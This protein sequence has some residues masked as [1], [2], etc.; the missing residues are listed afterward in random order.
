MIPERGDKQR[1]L[2]TF[3]YQCQKLYNAK[4]SSVEGLQVILHSS[5]RA[6]HARTRVMENKIKLK[7]DLRG[8]YAATHRVLNTQWLFHLHI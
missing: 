5:N 4:T 6:E 2:E 1:F 7:G 8:C 3:F